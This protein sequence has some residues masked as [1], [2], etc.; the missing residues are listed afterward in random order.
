MTKRLQTDP[1]LFQS[2]YPLEP[3]LSR[4][5][6]LK[7]QFFRVA[8]RDENNISDSSYIVHHTARC[9]AFPD[10]M[11]LKFQADAL[12]K[13]F[14]QWEFFYNISS[15]AIIHERALERIMQFASHDIQPIKAELVSSPHAK[16]KFLI[17][18]WYAMHFLTKLELLDVEKTEFTEE[19]LKTL[20][21]QGIKHV[22]GV[23]MSKKIFHDDKWDGH[24]CAIDAFTYSN[25]W[26]PRVAW[27]LRDSKDMFFIKAGERG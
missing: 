21:E 14:V 19:G 26:H 25:L 7:Y 27:E 20:K 17:K 2:T 9:K 10:D 5:I 23:D 15:F 11:I 6:G 3:E 4:Y 18:D 22:S 1:S 13:N 24:F 16:E 12:H 8:K